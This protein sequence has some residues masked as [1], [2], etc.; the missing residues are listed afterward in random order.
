MKILHLEKIQPRT[1][2]STLRWILTR[3]GVGNVVVEF[4]RCRKFCAHRGHDVAA[5]AAFEIPHVA[6][7]LVTDFPK[8]DGYTNTCVKGRNT[9]TTHIFILFHMVTSFSLIS[10]LK[11]GHVMHERATWK[12]NEGISLPKAFLFKTCIRDCGMLPESCFPV[13][14]RGPQC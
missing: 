8:T 6:V 4:P 13:T 11:H 1:S 2:F 9:W 5:I 3:G 7:T 10:L 12:R 14:A